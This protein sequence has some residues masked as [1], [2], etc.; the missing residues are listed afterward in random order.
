MDFGRGLS[1]RARRVAGAGRLELEGWQPSQVPA[2]KA[3]CFSEIIAHQL[4]VFVH[5]GETAEGVIERIRGEHAM[6]IQS[7]GLRS[8]SA[9]HAPTSGVPLL[10]ENPHDRSR[11]LPPGAGG[12][13]RLAG[14]D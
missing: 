4:R 5:V 9:N 7:F 14:S 2:L 12:G 11:E 10:K 8:G 13:T 6:D 1:L 3:G